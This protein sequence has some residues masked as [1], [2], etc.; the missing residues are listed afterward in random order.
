M[1]L[2]KKVRVEKVRPLLL[3]GKRTLEIAEA[4]GYGHSSVRRYAQD[5]KRDFLEVMKSG[6][7]AKIL[8]RMLTE[9]IETYE[10]AKEDLEHIRDTT[11]NERI[12]LDAIN[13]IVK[14][15]NLKIETAQSLSLLPKPTE[16]LNIEV[17]KAQN[18]NFIDIENYLQKC[19]LE[20]QKKKEMI[21]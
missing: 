17:S 3:E 20:N 10:Q 5:I 4:T 19:K 8:D 21:E 15:T 18:Y 2:D 12:K 6:E 13:S 11:D 9:F 16:K 7:Q 1:K 14:T